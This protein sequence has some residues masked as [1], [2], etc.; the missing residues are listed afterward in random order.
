MGISAA[1]I[2]NLYLYG[3]KLAPANMLDE[4]IIRPATATAYTSV[5]INDYMDNGPGRF[6]S[7]SFFEI[8]KQFFSPVTSALPPGTYSKSQLA[9]MLGLDKIYIDIRQWECSDSIDDYAERVYVWNTT[10]FKIGDEAK[11]V[12]APDGQRYINDFSI[13]PYTTTGTE[14]FDFNSK[15]GL[16]SLG[17]EFFLKPTIDPSG[18]GRTVEIGFDGN[19]TTTTFTYADYQGAA[20]TAILPNPFLALSAYNKIMSLT[21]QLFQNGATQ[22]LYDFKPILYG[23][24]GNDSLTGVTT[25]RGVSVEDHRQLQYFSA[26]GIVYIGGSGSD[27]I[28]G[29]SSADHLLGGIGADTLYGG[30][31]NDML[32]GGDGYDTYLIEGQDTI[33]DSDGQGRILDKSGRAV[34]GFIQIRLDGSMVFLADPTIT[35]SGGTNLALTWADGNSVVLQNFKSGDFGIIITQ[36]T[37]PTVNTTITGDNYSNRIVGPDVDPDLS[38]DSSNTAGSDYALYGA[39]TNDHILAMGGNDD[40]FA[41]GGADWV[42]GGDGVDIIYGEDGDDLVEGGAGAD[43]LSGGAGDDRIYEDQEVD[44][45]T[46]IALGDGLGSGVQGDFLSGGSGRDIVVGGVGNDVLMGGAEEDVL[47]GGAGDDVIGADG[48][49]VNTQRSWQFTVGGFVGWGDAFSANDGSDV[50]YAGSGNDNVIGGGGSDVLYGEAGDDLLFGDYYSASLG[51]NGNDYLDGGAGND[52]LYGNGGADMLIGG[53]GSD[54]LYGDSSDTPD[55]VQGADYLDGGAGDDTLA[56]HGGS[57]RLIGGD[58]NDTMDGDITG[59]AAA[60]Y[61]NDV[62]DGGVGNDMMGGNGGSD[63]LTGGG[64]DDILIGDAAGLA[65]ELHG[66]DFLDGGLGNDKLYGDGGADT[67]IGG[68]GLDELYGESSDTPAT[69]QGDDYLD[70]GAGHDILNGGGGAD[71][72]LGGDGMDQLYGDADVTPVSALG[73]DYLDGGAGDDMLVGDGGSDTLFGGDGNDQMDGDGDGVGD[74]I[75]G[76]DFLDGGIGSD[77]LIG[78]GGADTLLGGDGNDTLQGDGLGVA[79]AVHGVDHL[80]GGMGNDTL[81]GDGGADVLAGGAGNDYLIG[82]DGDDSLNGGTGYDALE[83][84]AGN[85]AYLLQLGDGHDR[86]T[87]DLGSQALVFSSG[88][89]ASD[90]RFGSVS[91]FTTIEYSDTDYLYLDNKSF[92]SIQSF[93]FSNGSSLSTNEI[94]DLSGTYVGHQGIALADNQQRNSSYLIYSDV[95]VLNNFSTTINDAGGYDAITLQYQTDIFTGQPAMRLELQWT[96]VDGNDLVMNVLLRS[97]LGGVSNKMGEIRITNHFSGYAKGSGGVEKIQFSNMSLVDRD[98]A[99]S[100]LNIGSTQ[101]LFAENYETTSGRFLA[102][103]TSGGNISY[104]D[105]FVHV[106]TNAGDV[107]NTPS[108]VAQQN[109]YYGYGGDDAMTGGNER[110]TFYGGAGNDTM[111]GG[112]G[113]DTYHID[114]SD[115]DVVLDNGR[116]ESAVSNDALYIPAGIALSELV[117]VREGSDLLIGNAR[118][119]KFFEYDSAYQ[120]SGAYPYA[121][122]RLYGDGW[123]VNYLPAYLNQLGVHNTLLGTD[124]N[125]SLEGDGFINHIYGGAGN[126]RIYGM[127]KTQDGSFLDGDVLDGGAGWDFL[128]GG[129]GN[130]TLLGGDD[131]D[132]LIGDFEAPF[133]SYLTT[134]SGR[135]GRDTLDGGASDDTLWGGQDG[136][137]YKINIGG[138]FD[139]VSDVYASRY[140]AE[141]ASVNSDLTTLSSSSSSTY[142]SYSWSY[143]GSNQAMAGL[144]E[145]IRADLIALDSVVP[146]A[147]AVDTL[148]RFRD[149]M[150]TDQN[151]VVEFGAGI[152]PENIRVEWSAGVFVIGSGEDR[153]VL[154]VDIGAGEG[155]VIY[156]DGGGTNFGI[157]RF[158]FA[159]GTEYSLSQVLALD[160]TSGLIGGQLGSGADDTLIGSFY[161]DTISGDA[162]DDV[163]DSGAGYD[164][165][166]GGDGADILIGGRAGDELDGD[167][168]SDVYVI[169][170]ADAGGD[171]IYDSSGIYSLTGDVDTLSLGGIIQPDAILASLYVNDNLDGTD[172]NALNL[173]IPGADDVLSIY[174]DSTHYDGS[175]PIENGC[176]IER[177]QFLGGGNDRVFDLSSLVAAHWDALRTAA[178]L[179]MEISLFTPADLTSFDIT[180][181]AGFAGVDAALEYAQKGYVTHLKTIKGTIGADTLI[182]TSANERLIGLGGNDMLDG[183]AGADVM[184]GGLGNDTYV[185]D[186]ISDI[187]TENTGEGTDTVK[188]SINH[189][190]AATVENLSLTGVVA[191]NGTG[192]AQNNTLT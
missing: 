92:S 57:D 174:W 3:T 58:G 102:D 9:A 179:D 103:V 4:S 143:F 17:N 181:S 85:D 155:V 15:D 93:Q 107:I 145:D 131:L 8:V 100:E 123:E 168:G 164:Y 158:R 169:N 75:V 19:R 95:N 46:A 14:N 192:N 119:Q 40:V 137:T 124:G 88:I 70:G 141:L 33:I 104:V 28:N 90:I 98:Y 101:Q 106:G 151:D 65:A 128:V 154:A 84:G 48:T 125:D 21:D 30:T 109:D 133:D 76:S 29:T 146:I 61:G 160:T 59:L 72:L 91:N 111:I 39:A 112:L 188:S 148:S 87:D 177:I 144:P 147:E 89:S 166:M 73:N 2:T 142:S 37:V 115:Y 74:A 24:E 122:E 83:G 186:N 110:D 38:P 94:M 178:D 51:G 189:T 31:G 114:P 105:R 63:A 129:N 132:F 60:L 86:L 176:G 153:G 10:A 34:S 170:I 96:V 79:A 187:V 121:I 156:A 161:K 136:D 67:L 162:G 45:A 130:D 157:E 50:A 120:G 171:S 152:T 118:I 185:V 173:R 113:Y 99:V 56:G 117:F 126:D 53:V 22:F 43:I 183:G 7:P 82:D 54:Q 32:S 80:D 20:S 77:T 1:E 62:L 44:V 81:Y 127:T 78:G 26:H 182:G 108:Y 134:Q 47:I 42:E 35:V 11:F 36:D 135:H 49:Y 41:R 64:G 116:G 159:D 66:N 16:A 191:I 149:W 140:Q 163:I 18:I 6:A 68:D 190:L 139:E 23:T 175:G 55:S 180:N 5:D 167:A 165:L 69:V 12:I 25:V 27:A 13:V 71:T 184:I 138:G 97:Y 150:I 52:R 172:F